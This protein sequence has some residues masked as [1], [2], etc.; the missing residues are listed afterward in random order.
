MSINLYSKI[1]LSKYWLVSTSN[2]DISRWFSD[3]M[4]LNMDV[5]QINF[6]KEIDE[7]IDEV[8]YQKIKCI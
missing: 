1:N 5:T 4:S 2:E 6:E 7:I 8:T 3:F